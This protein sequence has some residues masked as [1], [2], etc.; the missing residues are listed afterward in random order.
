MPSRIDRVEIPF[1]FQNG[2]IVV[3]VQL[4]GYFPVKFIFD[5]GAETTIITNPRIAELLGMQYTRKFGILGADLET[6]LN[7]YLIKGVRLAFI[8]GVAPTQ[9][10]LVLDRDYFNLE[11]YVGENVLGVLGADVFKNYVVMIDYQAEKLVIHKKGGFGPSN[12]Y[13]AIP[14]IIEKNK[15][16]INVELTINKE[17]TIQSKLLI[18]TGAALT[19][20]LDADEEKNLHLPEKTI[21]GLIGYGISGELEGYV[22]RISSFKVDDIAFHNLVTN[23]RVITSKLDSTTISVVDQK[24]GLIGN[25]ILKHFKCVLDY[26]NKMLYMRPYR[27]NYYKK[28]AFDRSGLGLIMVGKQLQ[29]IMVSNVFEGSPG[30]ESGFRKGDI[31]KTVNGL[32]SLLMTYSGVVNKFRHKKNRKYRVKINRQGKILIL[33]LT[34]RDLI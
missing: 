6:V 12:K 26:P 5:T 34:L 15:P 22:G 8:K 24:D 14:M 33:N 4:Q 29:Q 7:A 28:V 2:F 18:D 19:L 17:Q 16:H 1:V 32:P 25:E 11:E 20:L 10:I 3:K 13:I 30:S 9:D 31:I 21:R 27:K 23:F